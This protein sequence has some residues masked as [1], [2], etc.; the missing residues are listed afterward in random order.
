MCHIWFR[1]DGRVERGG[2]TDIQTDKGKLQLYIFDN[3]IAGHVIV[4]LLTCRHHFFQRPHAHCIDVP[5][6]RKRMYIVEQSDGGAL[7]ANQTMIEN[8][9]HAI[10][11]YI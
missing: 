4:L 11:L 1:Y 9:P 8:T 5:P 10:Q 3:W 7:T 6:L 2:G